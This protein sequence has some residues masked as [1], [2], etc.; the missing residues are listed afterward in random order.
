MR[1][2]NLQSL[3]QGKIDELVISLG[4]CEADIK[5]VNQ[6]LQYD[7]YEGILKDRYRNL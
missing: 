2:I 6:L 7:S 5:Q 4:E 1:K 3:E